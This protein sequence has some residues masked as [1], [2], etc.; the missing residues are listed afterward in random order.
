MGNF[1]FSVYI[2][3]AALD[4]PKGRRA[5]LSLLHHGC[6]NILTILFFSE[7]RSFLPNGRVF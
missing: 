1:W 3:A 7:Q 6:G 2:Y 5:P 4:M